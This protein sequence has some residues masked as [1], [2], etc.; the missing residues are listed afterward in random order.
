MCSSAW[1]GG[2]LLA[3]KTRQKLGMQALPRFVSS[4]LY[5]QL[6]GFFKKMIMT[7]PSVL[8]ELKTVTE[9]VHEAL[10]VCFSTCIDF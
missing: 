4:I 6:G 1:E 3:V 7:V 2:S 8:K 10:Y 5:C 9:F